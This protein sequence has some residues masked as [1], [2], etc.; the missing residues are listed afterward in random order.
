MTKVFLALGSNVGNKEEH[1]RDAIHLLRGKIHQTVVAPFYTTKP[2]YYTDQDTFIN[3]VISG[4]TLL[5]P[6]ALLL[7]T[8]EV[9]KKIGRIARFN[10]GPRELDIDIL[11]YGDEIINSQHLIVPHPKLYERDFVLQ[12]LADIAPS[13]VDPATKKTMKQLLDELPQEGRSI[14]S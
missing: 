5:T 14:I 7:F 1:L 12:P 4:N 3:T 11:F 2:L 10:N 6:E 9:E 13:F 8:Q